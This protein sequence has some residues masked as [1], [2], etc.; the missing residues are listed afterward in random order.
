MFGIFKSKIS[1]ADYAKNSEILPVAENGDYAAFIIRINDSGKNFAASLQN[2]DG[3]KEL[4]NFIGI[5]ED[6]IKNG[7]FDNI[8]EEVDEMFR[9]SGMPKKERNLNVQRVVACKN[10][11]VFRWVPGE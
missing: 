10:E 3:Q 5:V 2:E 9:Y 4:S 6:R 11:S 7:D 1:I 8:F